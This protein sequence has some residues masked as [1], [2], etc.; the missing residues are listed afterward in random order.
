MKKDT[1]ALSELSKGMP[2]ITPAQGAFMQENVVVALCRAG[3]HCPTQVSLSGVA[4]KDIDI[5]WDDG[6]LTEQ[7]KAAHNDEQDNTEYAAVG[8]SALLTPYLTD[9]TIIQRSQKGTGYDY[10]LAKKET[11]FVFAALLEVSGIF[12]ETP[13]NTIVKRA[14]EKRKQIRKSE[15]MNLEEYISIVEFSTPKVLYEKL[16]LP[17][18]D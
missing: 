16:I 4:R 8:V 14:A 6:S 17:N 3:H 9:Y 18:E 10:A 12:R 15:K 2:G 11:P 1:V 7:M 13:D 5:I